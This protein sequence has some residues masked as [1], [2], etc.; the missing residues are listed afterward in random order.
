MAWKSSFFNGVAPSKVKPNYSADKCLCKFKK[1]QS[2]TKSTKKLTKIHKKILKTPRILKIIHKITRWNQELFFE[3]GRCLLEDFAFAG[4]SGIRFCRVLVAACISYKSTTH[5][6]TQ[7]PRQYIALW[8]KM[9]EIW[10]KLVDLL[11]FHDFFLPFSRNIC[12]F[13][14]L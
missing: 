4:R 6:L 1:L 10:Q 2:N 12:P 9:I 13:R 11:Q 3:R 5:S 8:F 7:K 14:F